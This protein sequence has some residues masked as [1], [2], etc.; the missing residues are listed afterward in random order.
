MTPTPSGPLLVRDARFREHALP[1][2]PER[3]ERLDAIDRALTSLGD[4]A[5][6]REP[7]PATDEEILRVHSRKHLSA[8]MDTAGGSHELDPDTF[9][10]PR[11]AEVAR[12]AEGAAV[13]AA[14]SVARG[15]VRS[16]FALVRPP[17]HHAE[18]A[19]P[20][21]FCLLNNIAIAAR[22][23]L[24]DGLERIAIVDWDVHHGNGTQ[25]AFEAERDVL[26][27]SLHQFPL[28]P[29]TGA[30]SEMGHGPGEGTTVNVPLPAGCGDREYETGFDGL[31]LP[32]LRQFRPELI[33]VSA[34]F[35]AHEDDPL[36]GMCVTTQGF[37]SLAARLRS[38]AEALCGGR[39]ALTL[40]GGYDLRALG[41]SVRGVV[42]VLAAPTS[43]TV[44]SDPTPGHEPKALASAFRE[45]HARH[46]RALR[47]PS[48][49]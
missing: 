38:A 7:R 40:E 16:A 22:A 20:M 3:P 13:D 8:L 33:L 26:F 43:P 37:A 11:S 27:L 39:L 46:S 45:L 18:S 2:H 6:S 12:L 21:G 25:H 28:Y 10:S 29:G 19:R 24:A 47:R 9:A 44:G 14:R 49:S 5:V 17:G 4:R 1:G 31:V 36:A 41:A 48:D 32:L 42:D 35:D 15:D 23:L 30:V 34:G